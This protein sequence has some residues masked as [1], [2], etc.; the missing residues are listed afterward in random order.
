MTVSGGVGIGVL[1]PAVDSASV[2]IAYTSPEGTITHSVS[3]ASSGYYR[4][5][6]VPASKGAWHVQAHWDGDSMYLPSDSPECT[7]TFGAG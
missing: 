1:T 7:L 4:D 2:S 6:F 5:R 3:T